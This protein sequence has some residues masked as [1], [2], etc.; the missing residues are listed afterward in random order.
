MVEIKAV[1]ALAVH[2]ALNEKVGKV[3][4]AQKEQRAEFIE[5][6][7]DKAI[8]QIMRWEREATK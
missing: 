5:F 2:Y 8:D 7:V 4:G 6:V 3:K 1:A